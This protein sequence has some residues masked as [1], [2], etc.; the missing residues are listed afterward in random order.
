LMLCFSL[1]VCWPIFLPPKHLHENTTMRKMH[2]SWWALNFA[3]L[4]QTLGHGDCPQIYCCCYDCG[5]LIV[6]PIFHIVPAKLNFY[7]QNVPE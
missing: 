1:V 6:F 4:L 3:H 5:A 2:S 7:D